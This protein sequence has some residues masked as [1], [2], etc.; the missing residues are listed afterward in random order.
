MEDK[1]IS[2]INNAYKNILKFT[3]LSLSE[4]NFNDILLQNNIVGDMYC[5]VRKE[6]DGYKV[7]YVAV[8]SIYVD[9]IDDHFAIYLTMSLNGQSIVLNVE[10]DAKQT[11]GLKIDGVIESLRIGSEVL[12][13]SETETLLSY[14]SNTLKEDWINVNSADKSMII[15][16]TSMFSK[17]TEMIEF[18]N[19]LALIYPEQTLKT[20]IVDGKISIGF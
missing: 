3:E 8:E 7:S 1:F 13:D 17:N 4:S 15:D 19:H 16:F 20:K 5:F 10:V 12:S 9:L 18:I 6:A 11:S 2:Q 14:L